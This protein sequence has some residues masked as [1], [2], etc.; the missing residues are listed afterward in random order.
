MES[1]FFEDLMSTKKE[2][3]IP[4]FKIIITLTDRKGQ[5]LQDG[6]Q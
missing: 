2:I 1:G 3:G 5:H 6:V 4:E